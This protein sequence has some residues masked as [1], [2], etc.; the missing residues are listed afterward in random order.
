MAERSW[1]GVQ[2][3]ILPRGKWVIKPNK[4][5]Q[6][7]QVSGWFGQ[8]RRSTSKSLNLGS[9]VLPTEKLPFHAPQ[10]SG[11]VWSVEK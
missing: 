9:L 8:L 2:G 4:P 6:V 11:L 5:F 10:V 7:L 3:I 1:D